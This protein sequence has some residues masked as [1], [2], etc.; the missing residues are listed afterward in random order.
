V[1]DELAYV[2]STHQFLPGLH[3]KFRTHAAKDF[4]AAFRIHC[5]QIAHQF[6]AHSPFCILAAADTNRKKRRDD[7]NGDICRRHDRNK[8]AKGVSDNPT[9][10]GQPVAAVPFRGR[11]VL[12]KQTN[13]ETIGNQRQTCGGDRIA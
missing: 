6:V 13:Q 1:D 3:G 12:R 8:E 5:Y 2:K 10:A 9:P 4:F 7:P 11:R